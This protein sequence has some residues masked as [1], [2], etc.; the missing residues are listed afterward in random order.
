M[1]DSSE[2]ALSEVRL[3]S[4][5]WMGVKFRQPGVPSTLSN[6]L[7]RCIL[8]LYYLPAI[9]WLPVPAPLYSQ[10]VLGQVA[11]VNAT[12]KAASAN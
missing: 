8:T 4:L 3:A 1:L 12:S 2:D 9:R 7:H 10:L 11:T 6:C 5:P